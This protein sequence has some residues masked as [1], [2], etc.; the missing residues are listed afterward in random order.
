MTNASMRIPAKVANRSEGRRPRFLF[1]SGQPAQGNVAGPMC[2]WFQKSPC[3]EK[4]EMS[5]RDPLTDACR[6]FEVLRG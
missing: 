3:K 4:S 1:Q 5:R 2:R 6:F